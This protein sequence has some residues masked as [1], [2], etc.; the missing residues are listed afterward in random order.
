MAPGPC[1]RRVPGAGHQGGV[2]RGCMVRRAGAGHKLLAA[3]RDFGCVLAICAMI[4]QLP[5]ISKVGGTGYK[6]PSTQTPEPA[7]ACKPLSE[8]QDQ[9]ADAPHRHVGQQPVAG[10]RPAGA[11]AASGRCRGAR[12]ERRVCPGDGPRMGGRLPD[13]RR[14]SRR[15]VATC[16]VRPDPHRHAC[17]FLH[18]GAA[19][20]G[21]SWRGA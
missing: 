6:H 16:H 5:I 11:A 3:V 19:I 1:A 2:A 12:S 4:R 10:R 13:H 17:R 8:A 20:A 9:R 15:A 21:R 7:A 14:P 18:R